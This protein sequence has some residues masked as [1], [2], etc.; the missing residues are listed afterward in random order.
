MFIEIPSPLTIFVEFIETNN[1]KPNVELV[2]WPL[3]VKLEQSTEAQLETWDETTDAPAY[4]IPKTT[5]NITRGIKAK[6]EFLLQV[7]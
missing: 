7:K 4:P 1:S 5:P 3:V 6:A 2:V